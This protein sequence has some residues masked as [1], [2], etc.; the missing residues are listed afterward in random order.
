MSFI[1][2]SKRELAL[3][4]AWL[5]GYLE[6]AGSLQMYIEEEDG[7]RAEVFLR[8]QSKDR[9]PI[10]RIAKMASLRVKTKASGAFYVEG[11]NLN[12]RRI[13]L[14]VSEHMAPGSRRQG[15]VLAERLL[16]ILMS[17]AGMGQGTWSSASKSKARD[18]LD[19][20]RELRESGR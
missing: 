14:G 6:R 8:I 2:S 7:F 19:Q 11:R 18:I 1:E 15:F 12:I 9:E 4:K 17:Y 10:E 5:A 16:K 3:E 13:V 20:F